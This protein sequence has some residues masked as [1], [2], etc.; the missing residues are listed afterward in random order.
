M[1]GQFGHA[2]VES[3]EQFVHLCD[4][5][6]AITKVACSYDFSYVL[7]CDGSLYSCGITS[8]G[9]LARNDM[10][11]DFGKVTFFDSIPIRDVALSFQSILFQTSN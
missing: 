9:L 6:S 11:E 8:D 10:R 4:L 1:D 3:S 7:T 2:N 5:P